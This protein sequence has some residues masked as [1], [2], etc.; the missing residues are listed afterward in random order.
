MTPL[1]EKILEDMRAAAR[2]RPTEL[3]PAI[4]HA[5]ANIQIGLI[6]S[7]EEPSNRSNKI[8]EALEEILSSFIQEELRRDR[9]FDIFMSL[10]EEKRVPHV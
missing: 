5:V 1:A 6:G 7:I 2:A 10:P 3:Q 4:S 8:R 9:G